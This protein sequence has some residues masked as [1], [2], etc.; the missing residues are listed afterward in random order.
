VLNPEGELELVQPHHITTTAHLTVEGE[1]DDISGS[2]QTEAAHALCTGIPKSMQK[3]MEVEGAGHYGIFSGRRWRDV[4]YPTVRDFIA[5]YH[6]Q[7][8]SATPH[9]QPSTEP[10]AVAQTSAVVPEAQAFK[11]AKVVKVVNAVKKAS[12]TKATI[13]TTAKKPAPAEAA[14]PQAKRTRSTASKPSASVDVSPAPV[15]KTAARKT[16]RNKV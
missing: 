15:K 7:K 10:V 16:S 3:H 13:A 5:G 11:V 2:G 12:A 9:V 6:P 1:L 14:A 4:V 8:A